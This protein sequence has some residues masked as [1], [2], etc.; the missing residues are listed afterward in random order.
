PLIINRRQSGQQ[1]SYSKSYS[2]PRKVFSFESGWLNDK[3]RNILFINT[4]RRWC[5]SSYH[6]PVDIMPHIFTIHT[7]HHKKGER[8]MR[9]WNKRMLMVVILMIAAFSLAACGDDSDADGDDNTLEVIYRGP[10]NPI[11]SWMNDIK[12]QFEN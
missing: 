6:A 9:Y 2:M 10:D 8:K 11:K 3:I 7:G 5:F 4:S 1:P 12:E